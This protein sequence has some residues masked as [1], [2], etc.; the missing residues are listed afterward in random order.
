MSWDIQDWEDEIFRDKRRWEQVYIAITDHRKMRGACRVEDM[1]IC[2][3]CLTLG[4]QPPLKCCDDERIHSLADNKTDETGKRSF[5]RSWVN[6][7]TKSASKLKPKGSDREVTVAEAQ[8][9]LASLRLNVNQLIDDAITLFEKGSYQIAGFLALVAEEELVKMVWFSLEHMNRCTPEFS[10]PIKDAKPGFTFKR[11]YLASK[12]LRFKWEY[13]ETG[14]KGFFDLQDGKYDMADHDQ[15]LKMAMDLS[16][17]MMGYR[18]TQIMELDH[19]G[20]YYAL[21]HHEKKLIKYLRYVDLDFDHSRLQKPWNLMTQEQAFD[22]ICFAAALCHDWN[23]H[24][25]FLSE[26]GKPIHHEAMWEFQRQSRKRYDDFLNAHHDIS[27]RVFPVP[28]LTG[29]E[30]DLLRRE[31]NY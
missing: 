5:I 31:A 7:V 30:K 19:F 17:F 21:Y 25:G 23:P 27:S 18:G 26:G 15:K 8:E 22:R 11:L 9:Y 1:Y 12:G 16:N 6:H 29:E 2:D 20:K 4:T 10:Y 3:N 14:W 24:G 28:H 13:A